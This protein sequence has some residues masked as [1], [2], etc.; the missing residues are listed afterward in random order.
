[1]PNSLKA[2]I[3]KLAHKGC[4]SSAEC[5]EL[6]MKLD[7]HDSEIR[8]KTIDEC[9][10]AI[11]AEYYDCGYGDYHEVEMVVRLLKQMKG[12]K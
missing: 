8:A 10:N 12:E 3:K 5:D 4:I 2:M 7:G 9:I 1:M 6:L 11:D